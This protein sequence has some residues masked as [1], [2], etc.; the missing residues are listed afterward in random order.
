MERSM[1][2]K[3]KW[4]VLAGV[5]VFVL[6]MYPLLREMYVAVFVLPPDRYLSEARKD[7]LSRFA[8]EM[9]RKSQS[10]VLNV[11]G[12]TL[13]GLGP[14]ERGNPT[15]AEVES[16]RR[17]LRKHHLHH[18]AMDKRSGSVR[19]GHYL[20][21]KTWLEYIYVTDGGFVP[22]WPDRPSNPRRVAEHW[23]FTAW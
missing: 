9:L 14:V 22:A 4:I 2:K 18:F 5:S 8:E 13:W 20:L 17:L 16:I 23:Y 7:E 11:R 6:I 15:N 19:Y 21:T 10:P 12:L 3:H 1:R